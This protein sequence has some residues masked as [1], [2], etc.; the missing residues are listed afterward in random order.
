MP[1]LGRAAGVAGEQP[2][3]Q[4][5]PAAHPGAQGEDDGALRVLGAAGHRLAVGGGIGVVG[6][7]HRHPQPLAQNAAD[8]KHL[9]AKVVGVQHH[10]RVGVHRAGA[11]Y[12]HPGYRAFRL[13]DQLPTQAQNVLTDG[14]GRAGQSGGAAHLAQDA[15]PV[16]HQGSLDVGAAQIDPDRLHK[17]LPPQ[18]LKLAGWVFLISINSL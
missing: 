17:K 12:A 7:G 10:A 8:G 6:K 1:R 9:P 18:P 11:A 2:A 16:P 5:D 4:D 15:P 3:V 14:L 13:P